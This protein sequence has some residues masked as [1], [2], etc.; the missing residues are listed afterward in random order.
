MSVPVDRYLRSFLRAGGIRMKKL[1]GIALSL[2]VWIGAAASGARAQNLGIGD[3]APK[4]D[5]KA[6]L[7]GEPVSKFEPGKLYVLEFWASWCGPCIENIPHLTELQRKYRGVTFIGVSIWEKDQAEVRPFVDKIGECM[8]YRVAVDSVAE[9]ED[10]FNGAMGKAWMDAAGQKFIPTAFVV[11]QEG[12]IVWIG[13]P[14]DLDRPMAKIVAGSWDLATAREERQRA[15][16]EEAT[17]LRLMGKVETALGTGDPGKIIAAVDEI[18]GEAPKAELTLGSEKLDALINLGPQDRALEYAKKLSQTQM[19]EYSQGLNV[20]AWRIV[21]PAVK[22]KLDEKLIQ[23][24]LDIARRAD[25][26]ADGRFPP[27]ADTLARAYF[28]AGDMTKA[29]ETQERA[30]RLAQGTFYEREGMKN[31]LEQYK[32]AAAK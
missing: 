1:V 20:I 8:S 2:V 17:I 18:V 31:R 10:R 9:K 28:V 25:E 5:V 12:K 15:T 16:K 4:I 24:A 27:I 11:N 14:T 3:P 19:G 29:L 26:K 30:V 21:R 23:F 32:R 13:D 22:F 7:K 6:F